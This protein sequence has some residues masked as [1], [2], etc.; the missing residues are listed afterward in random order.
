M[1]IVEMK[2]NCYP[3][4][5][6]ETEHWAFYSEDNLSNLWHKRLMHV[7]YGSLMK[8]ASN[9]LVESFPAIVKTDKLCQVCQFGKQS[10]KSFSK[11]KRWKASLKLEL[12]HTNICG[13]M[14]T[15]SLNKSKFYIVFI[16]DM[17]R[18]CWIYF[19][20]HNSEAF[21]KFIIFKASVKTQYGIKIKVL[22]SDNG[23]KYT[24][25][26]LKSFWQ[27]IVSNIS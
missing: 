19:L 10:R 17:T 20:K 22:I 14:K 18:F 2:N 1:L 7:N 23:L 15:F 5:L 9:D 11:E 26:E 25:A 12:V 21:S 3:L 24:I 27:S 6:M 16:N 13:P 4:N 8:I